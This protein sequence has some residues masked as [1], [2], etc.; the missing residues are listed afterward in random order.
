MSHLL[1]FFPGLQN[2]PISSTGLKAVPPYFFF[3]PIPSPSC[4]YLLPNCPSLGPPSSL[5]PA[6]DTTGHT[7]IC[8]IL[9]F[10][11]KP[12]WFLLPIVFHW[13]L[14]LHPPLKPKGP[15]P[16]SFQA[17]AFSSFN[18]SLKLTS[19]MLPPILSPTPES[20]PPQ[21][22]SAAPPLQT[23]LQVNGASQH[24][25]TISF[26]HPELPS[27]QV[28][29]LKLFYS[30]RSQLKCQWVLHGPFSPPSLSSDWSRGQ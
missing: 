21:F 15:L 22:L 25:L 24:T 6:C 3:L 14:L 10:K 30:S 11:H 9:I 8:P 26:L 7:L 12:G 28:C 23:N 4:P 2:L 19:A 29:P 1:R 27:L 13:P 17:P 16:H 5:L 20:R 18:P